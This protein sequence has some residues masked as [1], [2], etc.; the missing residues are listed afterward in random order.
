MNLLIKLNW[1]FYIALFLMTNSGFARTYS[2]NAIWI[3][4]RITSDEYVFP[5]IRKKNQHNVE[6]FETDVVRWIELWLKANMDANFTFWFDP[7]MVIEEQIKNTN[8]LFESL[9]EK[10]LTNTQGSIQLKSIYESPTVAQ[11]EDYFCSDA[12]PQTPLYLRVDLLRIALGLDYVEGCPANEKCYFVY[13]DV[14]KGLV[15]SFYPS[16][17]Y[18]DWIYDLKEINLLDEDALKALLDYGLILRRGIHTTGIENNFFILSNQNQNMLNALRTI[19][20]ESNLK[21]IDAL[22]L[23]ERELRESLPAGNLKS[24]KIDRNIGRMPEFRGLP[25]DLIKK[26]RSYVYDSEALVFASMVRGPLMAYFYFLE[27]KLDLQRKQE[28]D[29]ADLFSRV[30]LKGGDNSALLDIGEH[31]TGKKL[32]LS[33]IDILPTKYMAGSEAASTKIIW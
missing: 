14:D 1:L 29:F 23:R 7:R 3:N 27:G 20:I 4:D 24:A 5:K 8:K 13:V 6:D 17:Y 15:K 31:A 33:N 30:D 32:E 16:R 18:Y 21:R 22:H 10:W 26:I 19:V 9:Q 12:N 11:Y 25:N 28:G 2:V